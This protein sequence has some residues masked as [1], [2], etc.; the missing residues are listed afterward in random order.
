MSDPIARTAR[1]VTAG[2]ENAIHGRFGREYAQIGAAGS[3]VPWCMRTLHLPIADPCHE[4]WDAMDPTERGR[5]CQKCTKEVHDLSSMDEAQARALLR[6]RAGARICVR[7]EHD[8][9]GRIHFRSSLARTALAGV[10]LAACT[11]HD[12][13]RLD[14]QPIDSI[15]PIVQTQQPVVVTPTVEP[16]PEPVHATKGEVAVEPPPEIHVRKG[17]VAVPNEPCDPPAPAVEPAPPR[18]RRTMGKPMRTNLDL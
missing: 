7:Y 10:A 17:D 3:R 1:Q 9:E 15:D 8:D 2:R 4:D 12:N 6:A 13:P 16:Q 18:L 5:F 14:V 11:P